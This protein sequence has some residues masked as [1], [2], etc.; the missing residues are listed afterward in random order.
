METIDYTSLFEHIS[1][2][3]LEAKLED[4]SRY[5]VRT[6]EVKRIMNGSRCFIVGRKGSGKTAIAEHLLQEEKDNTYS[7][8]ITLKHF[9]FQELYDRVDDKYTKPNRYITIWKY[10]FYCQ[11]AKLMLRNKAIDFACRK[12]LSILFPENDILLLQDKIRQWTSSSFNLSVLGT[13]FFVSGKKESESNDVPISEKVSILEKY[14]FDHIDGSRYFVIFDELDEDYKGIEKGVTD[15]YTELIVG[16]FKAI[17]DIKSIFVNRVKSIYPVLFI[18]D[19]I[20]SMLEDNDRTK[21]LDYQLHINWDEERLKNMLS[22]RIMA[23]V[24]STSDYDNKNISFENAWSIVCGSEYVPVGSKRN[25]KNSFK[26]IID[27]T[28]LRPRDLIRYLT[29]CANNVLESNGKLITSDIIKKSEKQ[30]SDYLR[31][32]IEDEIK[33]LLPEIGQ[34]M[35]CIAHIGKHNIST[36]EFSEGYKSYTESS[37]ITSNN[38]EYLLKILFHFSIIGDVLPKKNYLVF[39]YKD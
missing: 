33:G 12:K 37:R 27:M 23:D 29:M 1:D 7:E 26:F 2:W 19:D 36:D 16:L 14:I 34:V 18:R 15:N 10:V 24:S 35:D 9:P 8:K 39:K 28:Q 20:F 32:E 3:K 5:F 38:P 31:S 13:G 22:H 11:I 30:F 4:S 21:W 6:P 17:M 25:K